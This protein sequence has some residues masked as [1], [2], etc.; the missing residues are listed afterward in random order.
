MNSIVEMRFGSHLYGT[1]T[2][3]SDTDYKSVFIPDPRD[4]LLQRVPNTVN[5]N[6]KTDT[7]GKNTAA[8]VDREAFSLQKFLNLA[9]DGQTVAMD[10]LFAPPEMCSLSSPLWTHIQSERH[11]LLSRRCQAFLGYCRSQANKYGIKGSR[12]SAARQARDIFD[13][14][15]AGNPT[16]LK[17]S[18][19][20]ALLR[21]R[22]EGVEHA[23]F[24]TRTMPGP[25]E[26]THL[27]VCGRQ[28]PYTASIKTAFEIYDR[29][30]TEYG[31]RALAAEKN[32]GVD[33][34][35]LSHAVRVGGQAIELLTTGHITFPR[36][37]AAHLV[38]I[39]TGA[40]PY[41]A[42]AEE[43][44]TLLERV[45]AAARESTLPE[46][47]D[48]AWID[49]LVVFH[50]GAAVKEMGRIRVNYVP[51]TTGRWGSHYHF[52]PVGP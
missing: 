38:A 25:T 31:Q 17:V 10:M 6:S 48:R 28:V 21:A 24:V 15:L 43:L 20:D 47:P 3:A 34:K 7:R 19:N 18:E 33:W 5:R 8:D 36:P 26:V 50:Y 30:F 1:A 13:W 45:E 42:V 23:E 12:M 39:K 41:Q 49:D 29:L 2:P 40:L 27:S 9:A 46:E 14:L 11:R 22:F 51:T 37:D 52:D 16:N 35:A 4:I 32:E 44:E